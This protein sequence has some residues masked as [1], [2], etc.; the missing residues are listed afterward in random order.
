MQ[1]MFQ[2]RSEEKEVRLFSGTE[3]TSVDLQR[4]PEGT[5]VGRREPTETRTSVCVCGFSIQY[6]CQ[7]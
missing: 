5:R 4:S 1:S 6:K 3:L 2:T 7:L